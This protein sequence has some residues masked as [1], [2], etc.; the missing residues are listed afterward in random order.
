M[1]EVAAGSSDVILQH[2]LGCSKPGNATL[3]GGPPGAF[4]VPA[5]SGA[6][7][8]LSSADAMNVLKCAVGNKAQQSFSETNMLYI[9]ALAVMLLVMLLFNAIACWYLLWL[10]RKE[11]ERKYGHLKE[12]ELAKAGNSKGVGGDLEAAGGGGGRGAAGAPAPAGAAESSSGVRQRA[13]GGEGGSSGWG[14]TS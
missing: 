8:T 5:P 9:G 14:T 7:A 4:A 1:S 6:N 3:P 11:H 12:A 2:V 13:P 10:A